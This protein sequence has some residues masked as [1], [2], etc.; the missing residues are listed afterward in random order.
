MR[1]CGF[2]MIEMLA[3]VGVIGILAGMAVTLGSGVN[4][5]VEDVKLRQDV[6][7]LNSAVRAYLADGGDLTGMDVG[8]I[9]V[10]LRKEADDSVKSKIAG[11]RGSYVDQR[12]IAT[13]MTTEEAEGDMPRAVW[14]ASTERFVVDT[15]GVGISELTLTGPNGD[16]SMFDTERSSTMAFASTANGWI[17]DFDDPIVINAR[18]TPDMQTVYD[19][20]EFVT[21]PTPP[22]VNKLDPPLFSIESGQFLDEDFD[23]MALELLAPAGNPAEAVI[24]FSV[25][26]SAYSEYEEALPVSGNDQI[27]AYA[28]MPGSDVYYR[29]SV[30]TE[31]YAL[32]EEEFAGSAAGAFRDPEGPWGMVSDIDTDAD[33]TAFEWGS[34]AGFATGSYVVFEG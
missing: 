13:I 3:A 4:T 26:G 11:Y 2:S 10:E 32:W 5:G 14:D 12:L 9:V 25:N 18:K 24:M 1:Q 34:P 30:K 33:S 27:S 16:E 29:S 23:T 20:P 28:D 15:E 6:A 21:P 19:I 17:W 8:Q 22:E 31:L 7:T